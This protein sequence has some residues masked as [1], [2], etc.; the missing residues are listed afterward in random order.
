MAKIEKGRESGPQLFFDFTW[1][2]IPQLYLGNPWAEKI[3][4]S[5]K[6]GRVWFG[7]TYFL[8]PWCLPVNL[9]YWSPLDTSLKLFCTSGPM[10]PGRKRYRMGFGRWRRLPGSELLMSSSLW[11]RSLS[12]KSWLKLYILQDICLEM[13]SWF[14]LSK[15]SFFWNHPLLPYQYVLIRH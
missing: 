13:G 2:Y 8:N 14:S 10:W 15:Y 6:T 3:T 11:H 7:D 9:P 1:K 4:F 12:Y 5:Q